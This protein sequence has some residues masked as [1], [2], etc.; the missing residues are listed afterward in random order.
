[1]TIWLTFECETSPKEFAPNFSKTARRTCNGYPADDI[2]W[3]MIGEKKLKIYL[4][5]LENYVCQSFKKKCVGPL[6]P[7]GAKVLDMP[8]MLESNRA[9]VKCTEENK[10][11][12]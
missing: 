12:K 5:N 6:F 7:H 2:V 1:M 4:G 11:P 10:R 3:L 8:E 9:C